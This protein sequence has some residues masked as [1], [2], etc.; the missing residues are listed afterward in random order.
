MWEGDMSAVRGPQWT[1][2][3][4][5]AGLDQTALRAAC[6]RRRFAKGDIVFHEGDPAGSFHLIDS[7]RVAIRLTTPRGDVVTVDILQAGDSFGEQALIDNSSI[8]SATVT[9]LEKVETLS[10]DA[11][12]FDQMRADHP[13]ID[14]FLLMVVSARLRSTSHQ[15]LEAL[16]LSADVRVMRC[17]LRLHSMFVTDNG[18][19]PVT[20]DQIASMTGMTRSTVNRLLQRVQ[21][22]GLVAITRSRIEILDEAGIRRRALM[23][24]T[25]PSP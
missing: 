19:I 24:S 25:T 14:R 15:L 2:L 6:R 18:S 5:M 1:D 21:V 3:S 12:T 13:L 8:R 11:A 10:L 23:S 7:G 20:Q 9:A 22:D 4:V 16:Y 17:L